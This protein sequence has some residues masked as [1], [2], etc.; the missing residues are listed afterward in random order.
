MFSSNQT[1]VVP[2]IPNYIEDVF[3]TWL[4]TGNGSTQTITNGIDVTGKG[5]LVWLKRRNSTNSHFLFDTARGVGTGS[6][7]LS[8]NTT[9]GGGA[10]A[11]IA[12]SST[13]F[14]LTQS[15]SNTNGNGATY[16]SWTFRKQPKWFDIQ[17]W[18]GTGSNTTIS[19]SLGSVPGCIMVKRTDTT[20]DWQVYHSNLANTE[21]LVL[22]TTAAK[23]TGAT[24]WNSTTPTSSVFSLGTDA[25]VNAS[26]GTYVAYIFAHNAGGFGLT[27][28][29]NVISCGSF[30][31]TFGTANSVNIGYEPQW[32][33]IKCTSQTDSWQLYDTMR[34]LSQTASLKLEPNSSN[35]ESDTA[36]MIPTATG[37]DITATGIGGG[38]FIYIAIRRGPMKVPTTGTSVY[39]GSLANPGV[40]ITTGFVPDTALTR[41]RDSSNPTYIGSRLQGNSVSLQTNDIT[42]EGG[43]DWSWNNPSKTFATNSISSPAIT[44][45]FGRGATC[46][47]VVCYTGT[48]SAGLALSHN[49]TVAP[50]LILLER[51]TGTPVFSN[52]SVYSKYLNGGVTPQNYYLSLNLTD[53][54]ATGSTIWN[55]T[56]PSSTTFT[57]GSATKVNASGSTYV[58]FLF[59]TCAGVSKVGSYTGNG[60]TQ[61]IACGFTGGAR[62]V[63]IKRTDNTGDWYVYDTARGMT[64]LTDPYLLLNDTAAESATLGSVT[65][66]TGGFTVNASILAAINTNGASYIFFSVA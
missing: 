47:D 33:L 65:T 49:L 62:F 3:S 36:G 11:D 10:G 44:W 51:R 42:A 64:V 56:A 37:F 63:L 59:A 4:Y 58:A 39:F 18:T 13:G 50:E 30:T 55:N 8:S 35:P 26:G 48:G 9:D 45:A 7:A 46:H 28:T 25:T 2:P 43:F 52:W 5:A 57:V 41:T 31:R 40:S 19:H 1:N 61:A 32:V 14:N 24:R 21:Y 66:T 23:A 6:Q 27:G 15:G 60:T 29:D 20:G 54:E 34:G 16:A 38:T 12:F 22:N 53:G 17:T